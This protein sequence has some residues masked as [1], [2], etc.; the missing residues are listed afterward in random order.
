MHKSLQ[1]ISL[2]QIKR[3]KFYTFS[4]IYQSTLDFIFV[5]E[6]SETELTDKESFLKKNI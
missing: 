1:D 3:K 2:L 6:N 4:A 5:F